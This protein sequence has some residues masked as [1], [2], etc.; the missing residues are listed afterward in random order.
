MNI[1]HNLLEEAYILAFIFYSFIIY[2]FY[3]FAISVI[4]LAV[5]QHFA[6]AI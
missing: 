2:P 4:S 5:I 1:I 3:L 6:L